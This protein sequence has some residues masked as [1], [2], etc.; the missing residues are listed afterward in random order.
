ME[1]RRQQFPPAEMSAVHLL[2]VQTAGDTSLIPGPDH[3]RDCNVG[4]AD[5]LLKFSCRAAGV[6]AKNPHLIEFRLSVISRTKSSA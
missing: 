6:G 1:S 3:F 2:L 5:L 4:L